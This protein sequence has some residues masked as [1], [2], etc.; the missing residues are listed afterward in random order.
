MQLCCLRDGLVSK[1]ATAV[2]W[3]IREPPESGKK[4]ELTI[5]SKDI[6]SGQ[7]IKFTETQQKV[8]LPILSDQECDS[9]FD[10]A[11]RPDNTQICAGGEEGKDTC[12][13]RGVHYGEHIYCSFV[14]YC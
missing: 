10:G 4:F 8:D 1:Y 11:V 7:I 3:G 13:V 14:I 12:R 6:S 9:K 2:G 5:Y